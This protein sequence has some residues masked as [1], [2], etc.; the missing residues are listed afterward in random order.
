MVWY[1]TM[2]IFVSASSKDEE[3]LMVTKVFRHQ[4][5][6]HVLDRGVNLVVWNSS[7]D[8]DSQNSGRFYISEQKTFLSEMYCETVP[9]PSYF[10]VLT[11]STRTSRQKTQI[12]PEIQSLASRK[13]TI[14][15]QHHHIK[16]KKS[17]F[18]PKLQH[19]TH[20]KKKPA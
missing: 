2:V 16:K 17:F 10:F 14:S 9:A 12:P 4:L 7:Q 6:L 15:S 5:L 18:V 20:P 13:I 11:S 1:V 8:D 19:L 3:R